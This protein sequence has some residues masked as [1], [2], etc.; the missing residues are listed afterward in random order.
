[1]GTHG[2]KLTEVVFHIWK[3]PQMLQSNFCRENDQYVAM[4]ASRGL[5]TTHDGEDNY[6]RTWR[7]TM[8]GVN[9]LDQKGYT[10]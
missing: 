3:V 2:K 4:A 10:L 5:I 8:A 7:I 1:M 9:Y 6:G